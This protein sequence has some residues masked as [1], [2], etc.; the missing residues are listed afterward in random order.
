V[1][2]SF[3]FFTEETIMRKTLQIASLLVGAALL[4]SVAMPAWAVDGVIL[5]DQNKA[6][7]GGVTPGDA[8]GF[9][10]TISQSGSY[11]LASNLTVPDD[12]TDGI[13]VQAD[14][15]TLDLNGFSIRG[16]RTCSGSPTTACTGPVGPFPTGIKVFDA[17]GAR[18]ATVR[19][20]SIT[21]FFT[22]VEI[23]SGAFARSALV[24]ELHVYSNSSIGIRADY[25][26]VRRCTATNNG[27][28]GI[29]ADGSVLENNVTTFNAYTGLSVGNA[30]VV[31]HNSSASNGQ[32]GIEGNNTV[33]GGNN[34]IGNTLGSM[35]PGILGM[36]SQGNNACGAYDSAG[37]C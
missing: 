29:Q 2:I 22:G 26:V 4:G 15:V 18:G 8:P 20:G 16:P 12:V 6:M 32:Y 36:V 37:T 9:P 25:S 1:P 33:F 31:M 14:S 28:H 23:E 24:E 17:R 34:L 27:L 21:G 11:R 35:R 3:T 19:N 5:I 13:V 30:S 7:A 10:V